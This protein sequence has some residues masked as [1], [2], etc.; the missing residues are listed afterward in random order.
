M[1]NK[2]KGRL[3]Y[4]N[5][6]KI[7]VHGIKFDSKLEL[8]FYD[9]LKDYGIDFKYQVIEV[10]QNKFK[11]FDGKSIREIKAI[12]DFIIET[13]H[14][15]WYIDT[16]GWKTE[17][18]KIKYKML[19]YNKFLNAIPYRVSMPKNKKEC[20]ELIEEIKKELGLEK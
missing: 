16:K 18:S 8:F 11:D 2:K 14:F 12:I 7:I 10:I 20:I 17:V 5:T 6:K 19:K 4:Y 15:T 9:L 3:N 1:L 13:N